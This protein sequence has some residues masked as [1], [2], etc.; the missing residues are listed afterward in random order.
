MLKNLDEILGVLM[1]EDDE[2]EEEEKKEAPPRE[3]NP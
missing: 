2:D 3:F 1:N